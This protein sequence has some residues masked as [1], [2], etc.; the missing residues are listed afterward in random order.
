METLRGFC[1]TVSDCGCVRAPLV[2][3]ESISELGEADLER[4]IALGK[5]LLDLAEVLEPG[6]GFFR[7]KLLLDLVPAMMQRTKRRAES[8]SISK[9][10]ALVGPNETHRPDETT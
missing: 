10:E 9:K 8:R 3:I 7:G 1:C 6:T 2:I 5:E 4:K